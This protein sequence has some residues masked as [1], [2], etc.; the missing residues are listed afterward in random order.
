MPSTYETVCPRCG[1][2]RTR[3]GYAPKH[4]RMC[5]SCSKELSWEHRRITIAGPLLQDT[6]V[7]VDHLV[8]WLEHDT[9]RSPWAQ[10]G[11]DRSPVD[12]LVKLRERLAFL[13]DE[14]M[15]T[16]PPADQGGTA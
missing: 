10:S 7:F 1:E 8:R 3:K 9:D 12:R 2:R 15:A 13:I 5:H 14:A 6:I 4:P 16:L 11:A